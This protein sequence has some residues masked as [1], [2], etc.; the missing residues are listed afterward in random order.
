MSNKPTVVL[1]LAMA[2]AACEA[3]AA[4]ISAEV[5]AERREIE[6][7]SCIAERIAL[8]ANDNLEML[9]AA[10]AHLPGTGGAARQYGEAFARYA[11]LRAAAAA[12]A[13][14]AVNI[15]ESAVD[16]ARYAQRG[17]SIKVRSPE[18]ESVEANAARAFQQQM[19]ATQVQPGHP[20][21]WED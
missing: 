2:A 14:S 20:C 12:Y 6:R 16:S 9:A 5:R 1:S 8:S 19:T 4:G 10:A 21:N 7:T 15:A 3:G 13:D 11:Q 17:A 18:P